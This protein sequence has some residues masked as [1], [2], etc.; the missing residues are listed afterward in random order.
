MVWNFLLV[1]SYSDFGAFWILGF[2]NRDVEISVDIG[3]L[4]N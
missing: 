1:T 3:E 2:Q 4:G